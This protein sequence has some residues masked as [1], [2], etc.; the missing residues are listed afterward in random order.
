MTSRYIPM[1]IESLKM[2]TVIEFDIHLN[3]KDKYILYREA[4]LPFDESARQKLLDH[5]VKEI[6]IDKCDKKKFFTYLE[7]N[8]NQIIDNKTIPPEKKSEFLYDTSKE[9]VID[10]FE[11]PESGN[12]IKRGLNIV[13]S[14][15]GHILAEKSSLYYMLRVA[16]RDYLTYTHSLNVSIYAIALA[17]SLNTF[18]KSEILELARGAMLH[19]IGKNKI[20]DTIINKNGALTDEEFEQV[21]KHT[22]YGV[23]ILKKTDVVPDKSYLP[24]S[25][26]QEKGDGSGYPKGLKLKDISPFG[27]ITAICDVF[28]ALTT[29]KPYKPA[30]STLNAIKIMSS[31]KGHFDPDLFKRFIILM[32]QK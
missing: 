8:I 15:L 26:H 17:S 9:V 25:E 18:N 1:P 5:N 24:V 20:S 6:F 2:D 16:S 28:D 11:N 23:A 31:L 32:T 13:S 12:N 27:R 14:N 19:D 7:Q 10:L 22:A 30:V 21:K 4:N 29:N 3:L